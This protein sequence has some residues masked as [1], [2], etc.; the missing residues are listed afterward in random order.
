MSVMT[1]SIAKLKTFRGREGHGFN[2]TLLRDGVEVALVYNDASGGE[3]RFEWENRLEETRLNTFLKGRVWQYDGYTYPMNPDV[4]V[5]DLVTAY[6]FKK[7]ID[8][9]CKKQTVFSLKGDP[10]GKFWTYNKP[11]SP[12][13]KATLVELYGDRLIKIWNAE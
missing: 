6:E 3:T 11:F 2:A 7:K 4:F 5:E 1:Y 10:E 8:R 13:V 12:E 9:A